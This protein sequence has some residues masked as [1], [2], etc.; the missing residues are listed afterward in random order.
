MVTC[1]QCI[2]CEKIF[3]LKT[4]YTRHLNRKNPCEKKVPNPYNKCEYCKQKYSRPDNLKRHY[5]TCPVKK[6]NG[7]IK[8]KLINNKSNKIDDEEAIQKITTNN[9]V[10]NTN[11]NKKK[12]Y[13]KQKIPKVIKDL[14]WDTYIG[15][16]KGVGPCYVCSGKINSKSFHC[17]HIVA[18][19]CG[20]KI[21][22]ENLRPVCATCN[23]SI[24]T[25]NMDEFK[26]KYFC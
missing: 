14:V 2:Q 24:G 7:N 25:Q 15:E 20:G 17:G 3:K 8:N 26:E 13:K 18:E 11:S 1:Y 10:T 12:L 22:I 9:P 6:I 23:G 19:A 4:D 21:T 5:K 16:E